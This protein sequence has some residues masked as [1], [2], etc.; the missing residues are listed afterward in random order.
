MRDHYLPDLHHLRL[1]L[2]EAAT[3]EGHAVRF[4]FN[5]LEFENFSWRGYAQMAPVQVGAVPPS[6]AQHRRGARRGWQGGVGRP[7]EGPDLRLVVVRESDLT[8]HAHPAQD[9][10]QA[11]PDLPR[12]FLA[13]L[14]IRQP[15]G[16]E[17]ERASLCE[18][19][20]QVGRLRQL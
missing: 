3:P 8:L 4:G 13:Y 2:E 10:G 19:G 15:G 7:L 14:P 18:R 6:Q 12:P 20:G 1:E 16:R 5:P 17:C 9:R 11:E